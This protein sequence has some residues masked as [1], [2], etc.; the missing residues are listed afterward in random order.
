MARYKYMYAYYQSVLCSATVHAALCRAAPRCTAPRR[1]T[2]HYPVL[3]VYEQST[4]TQPPLS[5]RIIALPARGNSIHK[6]KAASPTC[7]I[8]KPP[9]A[10]R[11]LFLPLPQ[12]VIKPPDDSTGYTDGR[13]N[14]DKHKHQTVGAGSAWEY[15]SGPFCNENHTGTAWEYSSGTFDYVYIK[16][17]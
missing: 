9:A 13:K 1:A 5:I 15:S 14:E 3:Y 8:I 4:T 6:P 7:Q 12:F 2:S 11:R 10:G 17:S 16:H